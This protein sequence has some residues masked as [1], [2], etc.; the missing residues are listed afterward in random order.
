MS[1]NVLE[2]TK[3]QP[4]RSLIR[5]KIMQKLPDLS[6]FT[7]TEQY[8]RWYPG[9]DIFLTDGVK[10]VTDELSSPWLISSIEHFLRKKSL[11]TLYHI[12]VRLEV[13]QNGKAILTLQN[14]NGTY[15]KRNFQHTDFPRE[16]VT[17]F[18]CP[19]NGKWIIMLPSE[20]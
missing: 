8:W 7:G 18:A 10:Y 11:K 19:Y 20:Y 9:S 16:G 2:I 1:T 4:C 14:D 6:G 12:E 17:F 15:G 5:R 13:K 3:K